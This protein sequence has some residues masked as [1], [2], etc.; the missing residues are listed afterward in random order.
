MIRRTSLKLLLVLS[1]LLLAGC[2]SRNPMDYLP[3]NAAYAVVNFQR[4][5]E[6]AGLKRA[7]AVMDHITELPAGIKP[8][9][10]YLSSAITPQSDSLYGALVGPPG[11]G[12]QV[13]EAVAKSGWKETKIDGMRAFGTTGRRGR[14]MYLI[15]LSDTGMLFAGSVADFGMMRTVAK[16][17]APAAVNSALFTKCIEDA[18]A[19][20]LTIAADISPFIEMAASRVGMVAALHPK[21]VEALRQVK[22]A[23][24]TGDWDQQ[25]VLALSAFLPDEQQRKDLAG[26]GNL[27]LQMLKARPD[28]KLPGIVGSLE[29]KPTADAVEVQLAFPKT[30]SDKLLDD[31]ESVTARA[32]KDPEERKRFLATELGQ[33]LQQTLR[34]L[35]QTR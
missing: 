24:L 33:L 25:P 6:Q 19:H 3:E 32:P 11:M 18:G 29:A 34:T 21:G 10:L 22:T 28:S 20:S 4:V 8:D 30:G 2:A 7:M 26:L 31:L 1:P 17:K 9:R 35:A 5:Q 15:P 23:R 12:K 14:E 27:A 16:R 13:E